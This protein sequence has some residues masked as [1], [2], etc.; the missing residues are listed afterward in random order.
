MQLLT[1]L[2]LFLL[3]AAVTWFFGG[4]LVGSID[5]IAKRFKASG[6]TVAFFVL[7]FL[8][9]ISELSVAI[10]STLDGIPQVSAGNLV[11]AS[12]V[13]LLFIIPLLAVLGRGI[14]LR[15]TLG[16]YTL[17]FALLVIGLP[18]LFALDG[19]VRPAEGLLMFLLYGTLLYF[20]RREEGGSKRQLASAALAIEKSIRRVRPV[21]DILKIFVGASFIFLAGNLLVGE[22]AFLAT[23]FGVPAS[24]IGL[25][26][27]SI[28]TNVPELVVAVRSILR[29]RNDIAFGNYMG[30]A[31]AN[32]GIFAVLALLNGTFAVERSEFLITFIL[33]AG[34]LSL[35]WRF[36]RSKHDIS[37]QEGLAL[38]AVYVIFLIAQVATFVRLAVD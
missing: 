35:F 32:T 31:A 29:H 9:S 18:S 14:D 8:T 15:H 34:G 20:M 23:Y 33:T 3:A 30:S 2:A 6:F 4:L 25:L 13:I 36:S 21:E 1:H 16:K 10:N 7:G 37:R 19:D 24:I 38:L 17:P 5:R 12:F 11:G 22:A 26:L 27:L 28:G